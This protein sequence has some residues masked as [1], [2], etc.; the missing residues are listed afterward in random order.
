MK[1]RGVIQALGAAAL[2]GVSTAIAKGLLATIGPQVLAGLLYLGS[3]GGLL[4]VWTTAR[5]RGQRAETPLQV[6]DLKW[7]SGAIVFG[8]MIGPVLLLLGLE[9][10]PA[11]AASLL[12]NLEGIFTAAIAWT[13]FR[14]NADRRIVTGMLAIVLGGALLSWQ[15]ALSWGG[16]L[17]PLAIV[18]ATCAWGIDNNLTQKI[19]A[20]DPVQIAM[21]KG[22]VAGSVNLALGIALGAGLPGGPR[23][24]AALALGFFS[25]GVSLVLFILALRDLG[26]ART[27]AYFSLAPFI[28]AL[29][30]YLIW[31]DRLTPLVA[32]AAVLM[33]IGLIIHLTERHTH[34]HTHDPVRHS[35]PHVHDEH[36]RHDHDPGDPPG[37]P[38]THLHVHARVTHEHPHYPDLHHRHSH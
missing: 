32:A 33:V 36:H 4:V 10:T 13:A 24:L 18:A 12:L 29:A 5:L 17:G 23:L 22:L 35:H 28:G 21:I 14:E 31:H 2:F 26:T 27:G 15:G 7:L 38:H 11:S 25:Y 20:S 1:R 6:S 30:A 3:G 19:A 16:I 9:R 8:G 34:V 37:E